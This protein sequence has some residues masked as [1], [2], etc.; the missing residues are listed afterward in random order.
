MVSGITGNHGA[1]I[2]DFRNRLCYNVIRQA[3]LA[4]QG[5]G[6]FA[7]NLCADYWSYFAR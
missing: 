2:A 5:I 4:T 7:Q 3:K 6:K 1:G